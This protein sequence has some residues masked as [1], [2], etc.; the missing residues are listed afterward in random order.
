MNNSLKFR[1]LDT[2]SLL[3]ISRPY[4]EA[5]SFRSIS[6]SLKPERVLKCV[7][8][9]KLIM[10]AMMLSASTVFASVPVEPATPST[11]LLNLITPRGVKAGG[12][13]TLKFS[14]LRLK[15]AEEIFFYDSGVSVVEIKP[16]DNNNINVKVKVEPNCRIGEHL[17]QVRTK[18]GISDFRSFFVGRLNE[19][20]EKEPNNDITKFQAIEKNVTVT[21]IVTNEDID[22]FKIS[23][24]K[25]ERISVEVQALRLGYL[26]DP[27]IALLDKNRFEIAVSDDEPLTKQD[28]YFSVLLPEDGDYFITVRESS[29]VGNGLSHYRMH[30]GNFPRPAT[31]YPLGGKKGQKL[32][33]QFIDAHQEGK[34][35]RAAG[36]EIQLAAAEGFRPGLDYT[37]DFGTTPTPMP[38]R[39][40]DL[41]NYMEAEPNN[42][43]KSLAK[44]EALPAPRAFNG[45]ISEPNDFDYFK[46]S[47]KKG[48]VFEV[49]CFARRLGSGL[50]PV[51]NIFNGKM[52][53]VVGNDDSRKTDSYIRFQVPADDT[54]YIRC[55]DHLRRGQPDFTYRIEVSPA[56]PKLTLGIKRNDRYSQRR[57]AIAVPQGSRFAVL[58][59]AKRQNFAGEIE[60]LA[61]NLPPGIKMVAPPML[62]SSNLMP[63]VFEAAADAPLSGALVDFKGKLK[64]ENTNVVGSFENSADFVLGQPNNS[65]YYSGKADKLPFAVIEKLPFKLEIVQPKVPMVRNGQMSIKVIAHKDEGFDENIN[66][67][68]PY[69]TAGVG[70]TY[71]VVMPK[72]KSEIHYPLNANSKALLGKFPMYVI[73]NSSF[74]GQAWSSSQMAELEIAEPF[75]TASIPRMSITRGEST[76]LI[77]KFKHLKPFEG[78]AKVEILGI[79]ANVTV[80]PAK[81]ITKDTKEI[82]FAITTN[83]KSP[84]GK[85][86]G[87]FC[88][89]TITQNGEPIVSRAGNAVL[90]INKPKPKPKPKV[91]VKKPAAKPPAKP[92][93]KLAPKPAVA[94]PVSAAKPVAKPAAPTAKPATKNP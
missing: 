8:V 90:Q 7:L 47:A 34:P 68:F 37:D 63:V 16:I 51:V 91:A 85:H 74:K 40:T 57:Q 41:D 23:G 65:L 21:G 92:T 17:A 24:K 9:T 6:V 67:Q 50:D 58:V 1:R 66:I 13:Y 33:L 84:F 42:D 54:Y 11:P 55:Y 15:E 52:K 70:T 25:G 78:Q 60:L 93:A 29:F 2:Q 12:E 77:C 82:A 88:R 27:A 31:V 76:Q 64:T 81:M 45:V 19:V 72:G 26:F 36:K 38:F 46:F 80:E 69:R 56:S 59:E 5:S 14:G 28:A 39:L 10:L 48:Q 71:Q 83:E 61:D 18:N 3:S 30:V 53:S 22:Y 75:A 4:F 79:P 86:G 35:V 62:R 20:A 73:G 89:L 49:E 44:V 32:N 94:K 43:M 87:V